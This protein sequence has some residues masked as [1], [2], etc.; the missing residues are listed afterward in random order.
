M[1]LVLLKGVW[2]SLGG[3]WEESCLKLGVIYLSISEQFAGIDYNN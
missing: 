2:N 1:N 3:F